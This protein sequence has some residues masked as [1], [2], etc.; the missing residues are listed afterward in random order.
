MEITQNNIINCY[1]QTN[2]NKPKNVNSN[3]LQDTKQI[4]RVDDI[5]MK[6]KTGEYKVN[7]DIIANSMVD[8]LI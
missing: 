5:K 2:I 8:Y 1:D 4:S 3:E 7:L 6:I